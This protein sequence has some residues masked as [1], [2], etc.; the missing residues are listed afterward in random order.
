M[1]GLVPLATLRPEGR[2]P[3]LTGRKVEPVDHQGGHDVAAELVDLVDR[4]RAGDARAWEEL[5]ARFRRLVAVITRS[6]RLGTDDAADVTQTTWLR[7]FESID[8]VRE[9]DSLAAWITTTARRECLRVRRSRTRELPC[10]E[11]EQHESRSFAAPGRE[12]I[13]DEHRATLRAAVH[14]LPDRHRRLMATLLASPTP[15]YADVAVALDMPVGSIGPT[16]GRAI[17]LLRR[18]PGILALAG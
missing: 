2:Q 12:I 6:F 15:S 9:P 5:V 7:L 18:D 3:A 13:R 16:R 4:A 14:G 1:S 8:R 10:D 17:E 11:M